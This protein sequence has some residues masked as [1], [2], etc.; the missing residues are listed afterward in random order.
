MPWAPPH[1]GVRLFLPAFAFMAALGGVGFRRLTTAGAKPQGRN[2]REHDDAP[3]QRDQSEAAWT[4]WTRTVCV[5]ELEIQIMS[6]SSLSLL[7]YKMQED[8]RDNHTYA[9]GRWQILQNI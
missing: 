4:T 1:D 6:D 2:G 3:D 5:D 8:N 7:Q 9:I